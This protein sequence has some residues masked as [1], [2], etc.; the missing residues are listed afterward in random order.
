MVAWYGPVWMLVM[1]P[2]LSDV[3]DQAKAWAFPRREFA[4]ANGSAPGS[5]R[6]FMFSA[7]ALWLTFAFSPMSLLVLD[8]KPRPR[9]M[10][11]HAQT[12]IAI[13]DYLREHPPEGL[14]ANPQWWGDWLVWDGPKDLQ[15]M[16]TTNAVH[17]VP[18][19]VWRD[20]LA[21]AGGQSNVHS[22]LSKYRINTI[23]V[24]KE[25][26]ADLHRVIRQSLAWKI[27]YEDDLGVI[28]V[29]NRTVSSEEDQA[30]EPDPDL[31]R[32]LENRSTEG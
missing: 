9:E 26:Q 15:V 24:H 11:Y 4:L 19:K 18:P 7:L 14:V 10:Q 20:Y 1:A 3:L 31:A 23:I 8:G 25:L 21:I 22:L 16:M 30:T 5:S 27:Q 17:I 2:H 6:I 13:T 29:R 32:S 28:A 12:P